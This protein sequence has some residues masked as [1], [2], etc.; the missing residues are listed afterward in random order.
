MNSTAMVLI[1]VSPL[2]ASV[3][4]EEAGELDAAPDQVA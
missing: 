2:C 1:T 3:A 4:G